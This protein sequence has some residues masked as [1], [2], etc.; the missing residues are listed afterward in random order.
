MIL[1][2]KDHM[3]CLHDTM[4]K[5][6]EYSISIPNPSPQD[7]HDS[8]EIYICNNFKLNIDSTDI[9]SGNGDDCV[10]IC[11]GKDL[12]RFSSVE[13][14]VWID[15]RLMHISDLDQYHE[16][17][18]KMY[19][20]HI[21]PCEASIFRIIYKR[22]KMHVDQKGDSFI[23]DLCSTHSIDL[24]EN[25]DVLSQVAQKLLEKGVIPPPIKILAKAQ[26]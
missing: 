2:I 20:L 4:L 6:P 8:V 7:I 21:L 16:L 3:A 5:L 11:T 22:I 9:F 13:N 17:Y 18:K 10:V 12:S 24:C 15:L 25:F 14:Y 23:N 19:C 26:K 1:V